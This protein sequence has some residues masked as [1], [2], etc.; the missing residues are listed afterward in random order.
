[1]K[2]VSGNS[3]SSKQIS[4]SKAA[5]ILSKFVSADNG[6]SQVTSAYLHRAS[7][8][9]NELKHLHKELNSPQS[10]KKHKRIHDDSG[11]VVVNYVHS[12]EINLELNHERQFDN[13]NGEK[14]I[15]TVAKFSEEFI[16]SNG[17]DEGNGRSEKNKKNKKKHHVESRRDGDSRVNYEEREGEGKL[18]TS[19]GREQSHENTVA[20]EK[21]KKQ[22]KEKK[23]DKEDNEGMS[24]KKMKRKHDDDF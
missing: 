8:A 24:K 6:A 14:S 5:K 10:H 15:Q 16:G 20:T 7:D 22:K 17:Y 23:K 13:E 2:T 9:F 3:V 19:L 12:F 4:L 18:P 21:G 11:N 1:M